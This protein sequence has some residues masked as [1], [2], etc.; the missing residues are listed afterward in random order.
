MSFGIASLGLFLEDFGLKTLESDGEPDSVRVESGH[1]APIYE[2]GAQTRMRR[3]PI[4][5]VASMTWEEGPDRVYGGL[6]NI[7]PHG[8]LVKTEATVEVG[9]EVE[10]E[11]AAIGTVPR[12][13]VEL[14]GEVRHATNLDERRAYGIEFGE[15]DD[16][17]KRKLKRL[18]NLAAGS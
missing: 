4:R 3:A 13:E 8:C 11:L 1:G 12:L 15:L 7:S 17:N 18:Y 14:T 2:H 10:L 16:E 6:A 9:T 5:G